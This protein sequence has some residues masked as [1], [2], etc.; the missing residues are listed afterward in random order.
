MARTITNTPEPR[1][2][3]RAKTVDNLPDVMEEHD[4]IAGVYSVYGGFAIDY[5]NGMT[6]HV[7][8]EGTDDIIV[9]VD[10]TNKM[11]NI[12]LD[13]A[14]RNKLARMLVTPSQAPS[15]TTFVAIGTNNA[16]TLIGLSE[17]KTML[18]I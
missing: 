18:G 11:I 8:L 1:Y 3:E 6:L 2:V 12:H 4:S 5:K 14:V 15:E 17:L 7:P 16:Q 13:A 10:E 9:D